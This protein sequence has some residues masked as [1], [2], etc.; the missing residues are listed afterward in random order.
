MHLYRKCVV[1]VIKDK[2]SICL[3]PLLLFSDLGK[4]FKI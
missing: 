2:G 4:E 3:K 1:N